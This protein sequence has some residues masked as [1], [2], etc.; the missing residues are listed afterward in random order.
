MKSVPITISAAPTPDGDGQDDDEETEEEDS[1]TGGVKLGARREVSVIVDGKAGKDA[2][3]DDDDEGWESG[4]S[5]SSVPTDEITSIPIE[6]HSHRYKSLHRHRHHSHNDPRPHHNLDGWHSHA[7]PTPHAVYH[8]EYELHL[9]SGRTAG[10]RSLARYYRQNLHNYPSAAERQTR[11]AIA[12]GEAADGDGEE[13][14]QTD[15]RGRQVARRS[16]MGMVGVTD[17]K[18]R[19]VKAVEHRERKRTQRIQAS[20][21][22]GNEKR[23]NRQKHFRVS[24]SVECK[25]RT[26]AEDLYRILCCNDGIP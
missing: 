25:L 26:I 1:A 5:L 21:N 12:D 17:A 20:Y 14:T 22:W 16:S 2:A 23:A 13:D 10:H 15:G 3:N 8:D 19:E 9:P 6:D 24:D 7:H 4:S 18:K 11:L